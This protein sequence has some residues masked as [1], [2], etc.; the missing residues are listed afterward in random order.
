M[1][2][3][4]V[5]GL[6]TRFRTERGVVQAVDNVS[7]DLEEG[8]TLAIVG[9]SGSGKSV[10]AMSVLGLIPRPPGEITAGR[11]MFE[12]RDLLE[13]SDEEM[14]EVRGDRIAMIFQEPMSSLNPALTI[15]LQVGEPLNRHRKMSWTESLKGAV[16][17]LRKVQIPDPASR[18]QAYPHQFSGG[19]R[20]RVM[21][22]MALA[23]QPKLIIADE[24]TTALDV[25]VQA[26]ILEL[27]KNLT[28]EFGSA[29]ILITHD[30]GVVA[31]YA[32]RVCVMY[33]GR[34]VE[35]GT[36]ADIYG[37]PRHPYTLGLMASIPRLDEDTQRRLVP[38][39]GQPPNLAALPPGCSFAPR[40][41]YVTDRC[42]SER[43]ALEAIAG[44]HMKAC[45][46]NVSNRV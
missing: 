12:G 22:A 6:T 15:G 29:M 9:E 20:Q 40:C 35:S 5:D 3:L 30:L 14:Q 38:I 31:R 41:R 8:E 27:L 4:E 39:E 1:P 34:I 32:D 16:G 28:R 21:I 25:T 43:P 24:P 7:F 26:Q 46:A 17:L 45:F 2:L 44:R 10:T 42:R 19:M 13:L 11:V 37:D 33:A 23:C 18:L 36:A